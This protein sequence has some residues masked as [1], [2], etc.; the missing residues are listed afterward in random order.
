LNVRYDPLLD[1]ARAW[2]QAIWDEKGKSGVQLTD[3][4]TQTTS[5]HPRDVAA[6]SELELALIKTTD[7]LVFM[8]NV[9]RE[10]AIRAEQAAVEARGLL[11]RRGILI[12]ETPPLEGPEEVECAGPSHSP[13]LPVRLRR[14]KDFVLAF[15]PEEGTDPVYFCSKRC[16][17][18]WREKQEKTDSQD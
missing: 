17:D 9:A 12:P 1:A 16:G 7:E 11:E 5:L 10:I 3:M 18:E 4:T 15:V 8:S 13:K 6:E 14:G 2:H